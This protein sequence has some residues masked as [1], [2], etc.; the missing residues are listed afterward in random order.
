MKHQG[1]ARYFGAIDSRRLR[2]IDDLVHD[3][4]IRITQRPGPYGDGRA[5]VVL[6]DVWQGRP[7]TGEEQR[8][9]A[10]FLRSEK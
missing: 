6:F 3:G 7:P 10:E 1:N 2:E 9:M 4:L 8:K 5:S